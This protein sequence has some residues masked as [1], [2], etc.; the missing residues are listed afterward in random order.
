MTYYKKSNELCHF[1]VLG[2]KW[3]VRR[4][5]NEDGSLTEAGKRRY[6]RELERNEHRKKKQDENQMIDPE[7]WVREDITNTRGAVN[8]A[9]NLARNAQELERNIKTKTTRMDLSQMSDKE[10]RE[11]INRE[12]LEKQ[13]NDLFN[14]KKVSKGREHVKEAL[15]IAVPLLGIV[16]T[17]LG[18]ALNVRNLRG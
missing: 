7:R 18:I 12:F 10:L 16:S 13:Y 9:Q 6:S 1:G 8:E 17:S 14:P 11:K 15:S 3:G 2:M 4:Y 5:E